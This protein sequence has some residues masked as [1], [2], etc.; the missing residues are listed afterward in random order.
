MRPSYFSIQ[1]MQGHGAQYANLLLSFLRVVAGKRQ[2]F[3]RPPLIFIV[4]AP[5]LLLFPPIFYSDGIEQLPIQ[6]SSKMHSSA[7]ILSALLLSLVSLGAAPL[8]ILFFTSDDMNYDS[9]GVCGGPIKDLTP[10]VDRL[11]S[12]GLRFQ[13]AYSTVAVC[14]PVRQIMQTGLYPHRNGSMGFFPLKPEVRTL[15]QQLHDAGYLISMFGK[16]KHNQPAEKFCLDVAD[17]TISRHP[18]KLAEATRKFLKMAREQSRPFFHN[19]NCYDPHRPFIGIRGPKDLAQGEPPSRW[20]KPEEITEVPGF[21]EDLPEIRRELAGYYTNVRR[22]DD[23]VGAVLKVLEEEGFA[24]NTLVMFYGGDHGMS[25]PFSKSNDYETSSRGSLIIRWPGVT[26]A[27]SVDQDHLVSTLDFTPT[28]LDAARLPPIPGIDGRSFL[29]VVKG[30]KLSGWDRVFTFYNAA[31]GNNWLPMRCMR[32]KD[33]SYIWNAWS[34]GKKKYYTE[35]MA[36]L[37]WKAMLAAAETDPEI[38]ARTEFYLHRVPEEF[39]DMSSDRFERTNL[40]ADP[41]RQEE[42]EGMRKELLGLMQR[43]GDP[44]AEALAHR[45]NKELIS[46]VLE[47]LKKEY[48]GRKA[49]R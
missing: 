28:L 25:F 32:T 41:A 9:T 37:T 11:A 6:H 33:R 35:N 2:D 42:I 19:V 16:G 27:G 23:A 38:K 10:N 22:L 5:A 39:Y 45:D 49:G 44:F 4:Q 48:G 1:G 20:I 7:L 36:G 43:T 15:N 12:E 26:K 47:K 17:D 30:E 3:V 40:I 34:D 8:N 18:S 24:E 31:F 46:A 13:Y 29:P 21:L 14:Q